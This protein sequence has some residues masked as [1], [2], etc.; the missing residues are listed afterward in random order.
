VKQDFEILDNSSISTSDASNLISPATESLVEF[1]LARNPWQDPED[2]YVDVSKLLER[3]P[4]VAEELMV[5]IAAMF[6]DE[7]STTTTSSATAATTAGSKKFSYT[8]SSADSDEGSYSPSD[9]SESASD[10]HG[11]KS[12]S[13]S[14]NT[15]NN[16]NSSNNNNNSNNSEKRKRDCDDNESDSS[17][18]MSSE[19]RSPRKT[20]HVVGGNK[21]RSGSDLAAYTEFFLMRAFMSFAVASIQSL[22]GLVGERSVALTCSAQGRAQRLHHELTQCCTS[23]MESAQCYS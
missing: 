13:S 8:K 23:W 6:P 20:R 12:S 16:N 19:T 9:D 22:A 14:N 17:L 4:V 11:A 2:L 5:Y 10:A 3:H 1:C 15:S 21:R 7:T 18:S